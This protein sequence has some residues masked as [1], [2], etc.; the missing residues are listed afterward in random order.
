M[1]DLNELLQNCLALAAQDK[2]STKNC[3]NLQLLEHIEEVVDIANGNCDF[4]Q[5]SGTIA[6]SSKIY[7]GRVDSLHQS[8]QRMVGYYTEGEQTAPEVQLGASAA[9]Q[10]DSDKPK[11][12]QRRKRGT[13][14]LTVPLESIQMPK[15]SDEL[16]LKVD[17]IY[18]QF[19]SI[20]S[21]CTTASMPICRQS[22]LVSTV[23]ENRSPDEHF[24]TLLTNF[25]SSYA[26]LLAGGSGTTQDPSSL[27]PHSLPPPVANPLDESICESGVFADFSCNLDT[28]ISATQDQCIEKLNELSASGSLTSASILN[29]F[30]D[31]SKFWSTEGRP[32]R[33]PPLPSRASSRAPA[34]KLPPKHGKS[35]VK[36]LAEIDFVGDLVPLLKRTG[37]PLTLDIKTCKPSK[38]AISER[39]VQKYTHALSEYETSRAFIVRFDNQLT[40]DAFGNFVSCNHELTAMSSHVMADNASFKNIS[41]SFH[42]LVEDDDAVLVYPPVDPAASVSDRLDDGASRRS[43]FSSVHD[44]GYAE[45]DSQRLPV[46]PT[47]GELFLQGN[48]GAGPTDGL[49][50]NVYRTKYE[51]LAKRVDMHS[52]KLEVEKEVS[53]ASQAKAAIAEHS[54]P[55]RAGL[56]DSTI[57]GQRSSG[58][59]LGALRR[60]PNIYVSDIVRDYPRYFTT[61]T[62]KRP[63]DI[64]PAYI[65]SALLHM[66][67]ESSLAL[68]N[69]PDG[70]II[71]MPPK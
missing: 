48:I 45:A 9:T 12:A 7:S 26:F 27:I 60:D 17:P 61:Q 50:I 10:G 62:A 37:G 39:Q 22:T 8:M 15:L 29:V 47:Q 57:H 6:A 69:T 40:S 34:P 2:I 56:S 65:F 3:W 68:A 66:A 23:P 13:G 30:A 55:N 42:S 38:L 59:L 58:T 32:A 24:C 71:V 14:S 16:F 49:N 51:I 46:S 54:T 36:V 11:L 53:E 70:D 41:S 63:S 5:I 25:M 19:H 1:G 28:T 43:S 33:K 31:D 21:V 44:L 4:V 52:L 67:G 20:E 64:T 35:S 18:S